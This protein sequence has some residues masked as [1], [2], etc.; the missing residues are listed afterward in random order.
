MTA[1]TYIQ[2]LAWSASP[3]WTFLGGHTYTSPPPTPEQSSLRP[4][5]QELY[6]SSERL[7]Q[8]GK[9]LHAN[10][11]LNLA[12]IMPLPPSTNLPKPILLLTSKKKSYRRTNSVHSNSSSSFRRVTWVQVTQTRP[13]SNGRPIYIETRMPRMWVTRLCWH[14]W[15]WGWGIVGR[16]SGG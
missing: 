14:T 9:S 15:R 5:T 16:K 2:R 8:N 6:C 3:G 13:N 12:H 7:Q 11:N 4:L 1:Q 10:N